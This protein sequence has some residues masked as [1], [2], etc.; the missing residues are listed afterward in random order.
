MES[1]L[2]RRRGPGSD[3]RGD[4]ARLEAQRLELTD[5]ERARFEGDAGLTTDLDGHEAFRGLTYAESLEYIVLMRRGLENEDSA[6]MRY[7]ELGDR[8]AAAQN[9]RVP[10]PGTP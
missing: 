6:F 7:V 3:P 1:K 4:T 10:S 2:K 9:A 8:H 5:E